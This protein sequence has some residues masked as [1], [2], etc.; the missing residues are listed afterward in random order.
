MISE[1][2]KKGDVL[3][4]RTGWRKAER[5]C[6]LTDGCAET[7]RRSK[8]RRIRRENTDE[9]D[10]NFKSKNDDIILEQSVLIFPQE[11]D[12]FARSEKTQCG[13]DNLLS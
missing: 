2:H 4:F 13:L 10:F 5:I 11:A 12:V 1:I 3:D 7:H 6:R 8:Q 9:C